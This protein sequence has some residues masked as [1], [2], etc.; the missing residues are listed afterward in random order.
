VIHPVTL[1]QR[2]ILAAA[3]A[4]VLDFALGFLGARLLP[5]HLQTL[6][7]RQN[8][9]IQPVGCVAMAISLFFGGWIGGRRFPPIGVAL[10]LLLQLLA[11]VVL[12]QIAHPA[13]PQRPLSSIVSSVLAS[14][15]LGF[16]LQLLAAALGALAG[17][18]L[19]RS[20]P[21]F[22]SPKEST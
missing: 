6:T 9:F 22:P 15:V 5:T 18:A 13:M 19:H 11:V 12:I 14:N 20:R 10:V 3:V 7:L 16:G 21:L 8:S 17:A 2:L 1:R 4:F